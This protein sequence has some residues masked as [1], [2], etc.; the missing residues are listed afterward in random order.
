MDALTDHHGVAVRHQSGE[1][2]TFQPVDLLLALRLGDRDATV[3]RVVRDNPI[4]LQAENLLAGTADL[5]G[6]VTRL[7]RSVATEN[8][9]LAARDAPW[10]HAFFVAEPTERLEQ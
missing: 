5:E 10:A 6:K 4:G 1:D 2:L 9:E 8:L 7:Q 3:R